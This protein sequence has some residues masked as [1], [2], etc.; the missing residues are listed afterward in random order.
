[1]S[2]DTVLFK[3]VV[4]SIF[5]LTYHVVLMSRK[6]LLFTRTKTDQY[7]SRYLQ[8][9][10]LILPVLEKRFVSEI[11]VTWNGWW[12]PL[13]WRNNSHFNSAKTLTFTLT[14]S[15]DACVRTYRA[16]HGDV[17]GGRHFLRQL[18]KSQPTVFSTEGKSLPIS[19]E[20]LLRL[21]SGKK[22][23]LPWD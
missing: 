12:N 14:N 8:P 13:R 6:T 15:H 20:I 16:L 17:I 21:S 18:K 10:A 7:F 19:W 11:E 9:M 1:M 5:S 22:K 4:R 23:Y 3:E 2:V